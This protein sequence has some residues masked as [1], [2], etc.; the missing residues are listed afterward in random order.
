MII[1]EDRRLTWNQSKSETDN[2]FNDEVDK[3]AS[4]AVLD[5]PVGEQVTA[6]AGR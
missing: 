2:D 6:R 4:R 3:F 1:T 5:A